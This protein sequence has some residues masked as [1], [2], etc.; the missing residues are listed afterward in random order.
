MPEVAR[1]NMIEVGEAAV[2][3]VKIEACA[4]V[5]QTLIGAIRNTASSCPGR[6]PTMFGGKVTVIY[7]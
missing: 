7:V 5:E 3:A 4:Q 2:R 6:N 1:C